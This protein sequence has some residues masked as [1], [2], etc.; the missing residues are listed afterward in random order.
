MLI[1]VNFVR[2]R[3]AT[4]ATL[5]PTA[6]SSEETHIESAEAEG[7]AQAAPQLS[8]ARLRVL[9]TLVSRAFQEH[10]VEQ[11]TIPEVCLYLLIPQ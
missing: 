4:E 11:L 9:S 3:A 2:F 6:G 10:R 8:E 1:A 7:G 5:V